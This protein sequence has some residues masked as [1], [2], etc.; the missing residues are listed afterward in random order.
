MP[1]FLQT[2]IS[3]SSIGREASEMSVSPAQNFSKPPPVPEVPTV[4]RT[5]GFVAANSSAAACAN[6]RDR[7]GAVDANGAGE[8]AAASAASA[9][10]VVVITAGSCPQGERTADGEHEELPHA[11]LLL[12]L[13]H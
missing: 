6:G 7:A 4:T 9:A 10:V 5:P 8:V 13:E 3:S 12:V 2:A 1:F 11:G